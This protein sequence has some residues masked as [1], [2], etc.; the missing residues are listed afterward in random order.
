MNALI[1]CLRHPTRPI[2]PIVEQRINQQP[3]TV[4]WDNEHG[5]GPRG[6]EIRDKFNRGRQMA[7][8]GE[9]DA[10]L[11]VEDDMILP[12]DALDWLAEIDAD[13][14]YALYVSR[15]D[16][17]SWLVVDSITPTR[18]YLASPASVTQSAGVYPCVGVGTGCTLIRRHVLESIPFRLIPENPNACPDWALGVDA[19]AGGFTQAVHTGVRCGHIVEYAPTW[20]I[21]PARNPP[22]VERWRIVGNDE[23]PGKGRKFYH[24]LRPLNR[25]GDRLYPPGDVI[26]L[27]QDAADIHL[28]RGQ[29]TA[30]RFKE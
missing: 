12:V 22:W 13:V 24:C 16:R 28:R 4:V 20:A 5:G 3:G 18:L 21:Y 17:K 15:Q 8:D 11:C 23:K 9:Y 26:A 14:T 25:D 19:A 29:V 7:L 10:M 1:Y 6:V 30:Y 2:A 27:T